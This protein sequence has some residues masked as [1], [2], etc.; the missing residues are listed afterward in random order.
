MLRSWN[1][2]NCCYLAG[3]AVTSIVDRIQ[4]ESF[5]SIFIYFD[6][7]LHFGSLKE[8]LAS[9]HNMHLLV[10]NNTNED[11]KPRRDISSTHNPPTIS[12]VIPFEEVDIR[13]LLHFLNIIDCPDHL[14]VVKQ[15]PRIPL[16]L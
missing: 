5:R 16:T 7:L 1:P 9:A 11:T 3:L 14:L 10:T 6:Y 8:T 2:H 13:K 4:I 15:D 12:L